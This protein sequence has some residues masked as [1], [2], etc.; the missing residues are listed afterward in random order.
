MKKLLLNSKNQGSRAKQGVLIIIILVVGFVTWFYIQQKPNVPEELYSPERLQD[1]GKIILSNTKF[2]TFQV[3]IFSVEFPDWQ[4]LELDPILIWPKE[5]S[6]KYTFLLHLSNPDGVKFLLTK[7]EVEPEYWEK[8]YPSI[9][10][11]IFTK[12][13]QILEEKGTLTHWQIVREDFFESGVLIESVAIVGTTNNSIQK[14]VFINEGGSLFIYSVGI[15]AH[16]KIF[17]DYR[18]LA[19]HIMNSVN[20][21]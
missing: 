15:T 19:E 4:R 7:R 18:P 1:L 17:N 16:E 9:F 5:I 11:E 10:Q 3:S 21:Y 14:S 12:E 2:K 6:Q 20:Y 8:P 13:Q